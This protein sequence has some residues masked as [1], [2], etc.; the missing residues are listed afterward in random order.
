MPKMVYTNVDKKCNTVGIQIPDTL[1]YLK[2][3]TSMDNKSGFFYALYHLNN[4]LILKCHLNTTPVCK[5]YT[6]TSFCT[7]LV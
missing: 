6:K 5:W 4:G 3:P 1:I 2:H 7:L